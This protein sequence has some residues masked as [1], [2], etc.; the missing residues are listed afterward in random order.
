[1]SKATQ[2]DYTA[3]ATGEADIP[4]P[5]VV[6]MSPTPT[7]GTGA[8]T[9]LEAMQAF[10][11]VEGATLSAVSRFTAAVEASG[12]ATYEAVE[13]FVLNSGIR[14]YD[15]KAEKHYLP[16][17]KAHLRDG[18]SSVVKALDNLAYLWADGRGKGSP[19]WAAVVDGS[20]LVTQC[21]KLRDDLAAA[22]RVKAAE[23]KAAARVEAQRAEASR[24][25]SERLAKEAEEA[26]F[27]AMTEEERADYDRAKEAERL[28]GLEEERIANLPNVVSFINGTLMTIAADLQRNPEAL[29]LL[30]PTSR[31]LIAALAG[32]VARMV[33]A[34]KA[35]EKAAQAIAA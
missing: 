17:K 3:P 27:A 33:K 22:G 6:P 12:L 2:K 1:M 5:V 4:A 31:A 21:A 29:P 24:A 30:T 20:P 7:T 9:M 14:C 11:G 19:Y 32:E 35:A 16:T 28:A 34:E 8:P 15:R 13:A 25:E 18:F 23:A 26:F 10:A